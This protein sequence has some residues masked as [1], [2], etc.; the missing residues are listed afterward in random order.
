MTPEEEGD[1]GRND[2]DGDGGGGGGDGDNDD[3]Y[4]VTCGHRQF[5][6]A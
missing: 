1:D 2:D 3:I 5:S 6:S 4:K